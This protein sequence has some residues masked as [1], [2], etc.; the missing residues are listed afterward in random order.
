MKPTTVEDEFILLAI[1][2]GKATNEGEYKTNNKIVKKIQ[3]I[4]NN[5]L[6]DKK[7]CS[8]FV[9]DLLHH[10]EP[11]VRLWV[12][13]IARDINYRT[14]ETKKLLLEIAKDDTLMLISFNAEI[15]L[16]EHFGVFL[17]DGK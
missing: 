16:K 17:R 4:K 5:L 10:I 14:D 8:R 1:K 13:S 6:K 7:M 11:N 15:I 3:K 9:D 12:C 2:Q